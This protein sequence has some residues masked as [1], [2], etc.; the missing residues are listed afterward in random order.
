MEIFATIQEAHQYAQEHGAVMILADGSQ[1]YVYLSWDEVPENL[2]P[3]NSTEEI[4]YY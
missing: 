4:V 3:A 2:R 1:V